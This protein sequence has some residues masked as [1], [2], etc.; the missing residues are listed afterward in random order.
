MPDGIDINLDNRFM[1][2]YVLYDDKIYR[3]SE[4]ISES[5]SKDM[6][7]KEDIYF[8]LIGHGAGYFF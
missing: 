6:I 1:E 2:K 5:H 4:F 3:L 7:S 8:L